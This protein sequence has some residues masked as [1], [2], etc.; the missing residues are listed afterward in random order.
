MTCT[1]STRINCLLTN[2]QQRSVQAHIPLG[3]LW[4]LSE[5][6]VAGPEPSQND[7]AVPLFPL[8]QCLPPPPQSGTLAPP[9]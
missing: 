4:C 8:K 7:P 3:P 1:G 9:Y 6:P 2:T 5:P